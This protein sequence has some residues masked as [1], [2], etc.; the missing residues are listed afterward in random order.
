MIQTSPFIA[1]AA[2]LLATVTAALLLR[3]VPK[4]ARHLQHSGESRYAS[5][6]G[7]RGYLAF[8]VFVHHS[9]I[10]WIFLRTGVFEFPP[11][12]FY[13]MLGQGSVALFFMITG[14][15]FWS[16]LLAQGRQHDWLAFGISRVFRL[17]PLYLPLM[18]AVFV[19]VFYLQNWQ[20]KEPVP[21]LFKQGLLWLTFDRPDVNQYPQTG[22]L[23]SN[24]TWTLAYE[25]F[26]YLALPL[27]ALVF[28]YRGNWL[29]VVLC[30][31]GIYALYQLVGWEHSLKKHFLA[32][33]LGGIAA[34]YWV[35]RPQL[36]AWSRTTLAS[37]IALV[38]LAL[39][40]TVFNR[41]FK[42]APLFLLSLFFVI[43]A[44]GNTLFGA[45][46]PRSIRWLG[47]ISYSTYLLHGFV[48]W[49]MVQRLPLALDL[50][51]RETWVY[52]PL[53]AAC[54]CLLILIS[55]ATFLYIEQP[56]MNAGRNVVQWIRQRQ[57]GS[58]KLSEKVAR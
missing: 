57:K 35:R 15:L 22:M 32:S 56:G 14:F 31:I 49:L 44:S 34:A 58:K 40:F 3:A 16:R 20:L 46:K 21:Q 28:V 37:V 25:V 12:N 13:S 43:V 54:T 45:L 27:A 29:Q 38:A 26:F 48:L 8:G 10:T 9:I 52:L 17:Y 18:L 19:T 51:A 2:Y 30:L 50:D 1:P 39:A 5:I 55:S 53:M 4:I 11:S 42:T 7:L 33:F 6:D 41:A 23:I 47:E 24:V 36:V